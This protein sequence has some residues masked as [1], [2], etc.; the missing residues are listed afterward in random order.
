EHRSA[1]DAAALRVEA[2]YR[3]GDH[4]GAL[5][6]QRELAERWPQNP[7]G[8][9]AGLFAGLAAA[10]AEDW[11]EGA[12]RLEETRRDFPHGAHTGQVELLLAQCRRQLGERE[13]AAEGFR[14]VAD[15]GGEEAP[16]AL[17]GLAGVLRELGRPAEA[18]G[19]LDKLL[20][21]SPAGPNA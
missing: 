12:R 16:E 11:R 14:A 15:R 20:E 1:P 17:L 3:A 2:L 4:A 9:R 6:A 13:A 7:T 19:A 18:G 5:I 21:Q 10:S 8:E